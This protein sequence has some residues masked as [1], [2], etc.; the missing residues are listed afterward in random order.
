MKMS[1][2]VEKKTK[3][4][5]KELPFYNTSIEKPYIKRLKNTYILRELFLMN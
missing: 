4:L 1:F 2:W 3:T 5:F